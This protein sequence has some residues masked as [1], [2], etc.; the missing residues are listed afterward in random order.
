M[1]SYSFTNGAQQLFTASDTLTFTDPVLL[2][3]DLNF[4]MSSGLGGPADE[5]VVR[6]EFGPLFGQTMTLVDF[7]GLRIGSAK[8]IFAS[9]GKLYFGDGKTSLDD[10]L[11]NI[12]TGTPASDMFIGLGGNDSLSGG[13][14]D[15]VFYMALGVGGVYSSGGVD[16]IRG[17]S[18]VDT[19]RCLET[20][21]EPVTVDL[22]AGTMSGGDDHGTSGAVLISIEKFAGTQWGDAIT[23]SSGANELVGRGG[24]DQMHGAGGADTLE[25]GA[26]ADLLDG[27]DGKDWVDYRHDAAGVSADLQGGMA[28][29]GSAA[30]DTLGSIENFVGSSFGDTVT[31]TGTANSILPGA[32]NDVVHAAGGAD[33]IDGGKG[34]DRLWGGG[35][36]DLIIGGVGND[37]MWG[38]G[39]SDTMIGSAAA[40][41]NLAN[42]EQTSGKDVFKSEKSAD[43]GMPLDIIFGFDASTSTANGGDASVDTIDLVAIFDTIGYTGTDPIGAGYMKVEDAGVNL[44]GGPA[45]ALIS[46]DMDGPGSSA[47]W[48]PVFQV[49]DVPAATLLSNPEFLLLQ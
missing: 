8:F 11:A 25:G 28:T 15:D 26:G 36:D 1:A 12:I 9:G 45:D 14:G 16:T 35:G 33:V 48:L 29:D 2:P 46:I 24:N 13:D 23:G 47:S 19:V 41:F 42:Y 21:F 43:A 18:G 34:S 44:N 39:G 40:F 49:A 38:G 4:D 17:G 32:G 5:L 3:G 20:A 7:D 22:G 31:G 27:G 6:V 30:T 37:T 10:E